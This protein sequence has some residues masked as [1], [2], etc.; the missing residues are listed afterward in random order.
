MH[1]RCIFRVTDPQGRVEHVGPRNVLVYYDTLQRVY[2]DAIF[3]P[4]KVK[5][6]K[7]SSGDN[8]LVIRSKSCFTGTR[9]FS[10]QWKVWN[11]RLTETS[12][13]VESM[14]VSEEEK[15]ILRM[16]YEDIKRKGQ[17]L[18]V[19]VRFTETFFVDVGACNKIVYMELNYKFI[20]FKA[21][22]LDLEMEAEAQL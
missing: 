15:E 7:N 2:P 8:F 21:S 4:M 20:S 10:E 18:E 16:R 12:V 6:V 22:H 13:V 14:D 17:N 9:I 11:P 19:L 5:I 1:P 3:V